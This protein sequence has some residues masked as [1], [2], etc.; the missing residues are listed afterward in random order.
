M[1][2]AATGGGTGAGSASATSGSGGMTAG[3]EA[4]GSGSAGVGGGDEVPR[5]VVDFTV[6]EPLPVH[7][8][9]TRFGGKTHTELVAL[10]PDGKRALARSTFFYPDGEDPLGQTEQLMLVQRGSPTVELGTL[11]GGEASALYNVHSYAEDVSLVAGSVQGWETSGR[12][13]WWEESEGLNELELPLEPSSVLVWMNQDRVAIVS[14]SI[15]DGPARLLRFKDGAWEQ[16]LPALPG[17]ESMSVY[18]VSPD[19][20]VVMGP[21]RAGAGCQEDCE[22]TFVWRAGEGTSALQPPAGASDCG[23]SG[24]PAL[25]GRRV[26]AGCQPD[27]ATGTKQILAE[28]LGW[29]EVGEG[30]KSKG[31]HYL[32]RDAK[33]AYGVT[34]GGTPEYSLWRWNAERGTE[35]L[36]IPGEGGYVNELSAV[37]AAT[38][39]G[40]TVLV[41]TRPPNPRALLWSP[42]GV[43][44]LQHPDGTEQGGAVGMSADGRIIS[45]YS[46][47]GGPVLWLDGKSY[48]LEELFEVAGFDLTNIQLGSPWV[49]GDGRNL[50][51]AGSVNGQPRA[52]FA[53][54]ELD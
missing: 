8:A 32:S 18:Y 24:R 23:V 52:W 27:A 6:I 35:L 36:K 21:A 51:G 42:S 17:F 44:V 4:G 53:R 48:W 19:G 22:R 29:I 9:R 13:F 34:V 5:V 10:S 45:G 54:I 31:V 16:D 30:P 20:S 38:A 33:S 37:I 49:L 3:T 25:G 43:T 39:D 15:G 47:T 1:P 50:H 7:A 11:G 46:A 41:E 26:L 28:D 14:A 2:S 40:E 12:A